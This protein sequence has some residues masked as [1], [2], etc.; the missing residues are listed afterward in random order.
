MCHTLCSHFEK[1]RPK[2]CQVCRLEVVQACLLSDSQ[3]TS[4]DQ[5]QLLVSATFIGHVSLSYGKQD[6][7]ILASNAYLLLPHIH[8]FSIDDTEV[9]VKP[10]PQIAHCQSITVNSAYDT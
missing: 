5:R 7:D 9:K 10:L 1:I 2:S 6:L 8:L 3:T 4:G